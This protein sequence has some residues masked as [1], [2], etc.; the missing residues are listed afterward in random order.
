M[1][2]KT[3]FITNRDDISIEYLISKF[4][5]KS[6][7]YLRINS[8]DIDT[9]NFEINPT[10]KSFCHIDST[11]YSLSNIK[12]I[13]FR[14]TP[15]KYNT[16]KNDPNSPYLN[17]E[18]KHFF[19][20]FYLTMQNA[21]WINPM[22]ATHIAERKLHQLQLA[23]TIGLEVPKS[24]ITNSANKADSFLKN[25]RKSIIKPISNGL[26][27]LPSKVYSIYTSEI[28]SNY[29]EHV[30]KETIFETP[31]FLQK[32]ITNIAD[33]RATIIANKIFVVKIEKD[34]N[35]EV[36][37]RK[38]NINKKYSII[39]LPKKLENKLFQINKNLSLTYSAID[40]IQMPNKEYFFLEVNPVGEWVW[41]EKEL[42]LKISEAF[43][44]ELL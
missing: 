7:Q 21:K 27:V 5:L 38:P 14:R 26:Q 44:N 3:L 31:V 11:T 17:N 12:S 1:N 15:T 28:E 30:P 8:E 18:K 36:D 22:F 2:V 13:V 35:N 25:N 42:G 6:K 10:G 29:F 23:N 32:K 41:L 24:I 34:D 40:L 20:G 19:E 9:I 43:I 39:N 4:R 33:I 37:W 16:L